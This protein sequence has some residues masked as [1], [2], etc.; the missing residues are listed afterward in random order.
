MKDYA[1][2]E[3]LHAAIMD[4]RPYDPQLINERPNLGAPAF[5]PTTPLTAE[6]LKKIGISP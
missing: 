4:A 3:R 1:G 2:T 6:E 5:W